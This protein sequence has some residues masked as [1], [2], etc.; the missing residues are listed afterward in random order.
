MSY[1]VDDRVMPVVTREELESSLKELSRGVRDPHEGILGPRSVA[2]KL[3]GDLAVFLGGGRAALLQLAHPM[4]A[5]AVDH[6]S[7]T[8]ADVVGRF[9]RTF[10][11]VFAMVFGELDE[12]FAAAR[13]VHSIHTRIHGEIPHQIGAWRAGAP[14]YANDADALRWVHATLVDTT[15]AVRE[16]L[17]G[18]LPTALKDTY[19]IEMNR[20]GALFGIPRDRLP[21]SWR[22]HEAYMQRMLGSDLLA[23]APCAK[24]MAMFLVGRAGSQAQPPLG[25]FA[26]ALTAT[27]LPN[28]LARDFGLVR[29]ALSTTGVQLA[30]SAFAPFYRRL[31]TRAVAIPARSMATRRLRGQGPSRF[32]SWTERQ[33]FGLTRQ[34]TGT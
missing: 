26:E 1:P 11:N 31:P 34:V 12:A 25:R 16:R 18:A 5:F 21:D 28:H 29:T 7:R 13:R 10:R 8:R 15:I 20:F 17:D 3:G 32:A 9:Q 19:I 27:M 4:V 23:V 2:W 6:H 24:E 33:L 22:A 30:L 14:Y